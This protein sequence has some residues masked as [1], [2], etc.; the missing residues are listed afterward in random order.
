MKVAF[1]CR[2]CVEHLVLRLSLLD[3]LARKLISYFTEA[4]TRNS[5][6]NKSRLT[7]MTS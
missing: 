5:T 4:L 6:E 1:I 2:F 7:V 3:G